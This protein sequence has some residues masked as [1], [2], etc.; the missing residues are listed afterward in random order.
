MLNKNKTMNLINE[1]FVHVFHYW[2]MYMLTEMMW[3]C[4]TC[5]ALFFQYFRVPRSYL[6]LSILMQEKINYFLEKIPIFVLY[7]E[8]NPIFVI[9]FGDTMFYFPIF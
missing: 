1:Y 8:E 7:W 2:Q 9:F 5:Q 4:S 6:I 3:T